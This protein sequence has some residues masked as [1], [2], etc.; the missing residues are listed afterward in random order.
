[1]RLLF[2]AT[3]L[4][5]A[6]GASAAGGRFV[7]HEQ[8]G[9]DGLPARM[10]T[11][12]LPAEYDA[13]PG[14]RFGV[15]YLH[16]GQNVFDPARSSFGTEW[17]ADEAVAGLMAS[18]ELPAMIVVGVDN[19]PRRRAEYAP[20]QEGDV[21]RAWFAGPLREFID[22]NYR[23]VDAPNHRWVGGA[24][25]GGLVS[26][27]LAWEHPE[28]YGAAICMSPAFKYLNFDYPAGLEGPAPACT[29]FYIDN[30]TEELEKEL[31]PGVEAMVA[32]LPELGC[33]ENTCFTLFIEEGARHFEADW[34]RRLP[35]ALRACQSFSAASR[36]EPGP[37]TH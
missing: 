10:V 14:E 30:G 29:H 16:D 15:L 35:G 25:M 33:P 13:S 8:L 31:Q 36:S 18:G 5:A 6:M 1:M 9:S 22:A 2:F 12:W 23:T 28:L 11:V 4:L 34:A 20:G 21:Y 32:R 17:S 3:F 27:M 37:C 19:S 26:F 24:S 7:V